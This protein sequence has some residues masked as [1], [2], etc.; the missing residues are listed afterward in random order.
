MLPFIIYIITK[1]G[2]LR[3]LLLF[4]LQIGF[5]SNRL[6]TAQLVQ[7]IEWIQSNQTN[8]LTAKLIDDSGFSYFHFLLWNIRLLVRS[9]AH[10]ILFGRSISFCSTKNS[11]KSS[12]SLHKFQCL[13]WNSI[14][15]NIIEER[16]ILNLPQYNFAFLYIRMCVIYSFHIFPCTKLLRI[17]FFVHQSNEH[18]SSSFYL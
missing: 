6:S 4:S 15:S 11:W 7:P 1:K 17:F 16:F 18:S 2:I 8:R 9:L 13:H 14:K 3:A 5:D 12:E 10:F